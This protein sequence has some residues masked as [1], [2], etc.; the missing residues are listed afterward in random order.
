MHQLGGTTG[1]TT[2]SGAVV[3]S[4]SVAATDSSSVTYSV[5]FNES[6]SGVSAADFSVSTTPNLTQSG[7]LL[8]TGS[9]SSYQVKI[10]GLDG[11][12]EVFIMLSP[13]ATISGSSGSV[14]PSLGSSVSNIFSFSAPEITRPMGQAL[15]A[16]EYQG[17]TYI[18][19][20]SQDNPLAHQANDE[21]YAFLHSASSASLNSA[22]VDSI[23]P[24]DTYTTFLS[25]MVRVA[26]LRYAYK[27]AI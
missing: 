18:D 13:D 19:A 4:W 20:T 27:D 14:G 21:Y 2:R 11:T 6:V 9:G 22:T 26:L 16:S 3:S 17:T 8:V 15:V 23:A 24:Y 25:L 7:G 12:G 5:Q 10:P 1:A